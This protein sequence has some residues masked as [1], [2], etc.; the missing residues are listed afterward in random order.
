MQANYVLNRLSE[1]ETDV[2]YFSMHLATQYNIIL[3]YFLLHVIKLISKMRSTKVT[4]LC[5]SD[6]QKGNLCPSYRNLVLVQPSIL[7]SRQCHVPE[8]YMLPLKVY[9]SPYQSLHAQK[10]TVCTLLYTTHLMLLY[11]PCFNG[12][13]VA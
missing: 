11:T 2:L 6:A 1:V 8:K 9:Y 5:P 12:A 13:I 10:M 3:Y 7:T 4:Q